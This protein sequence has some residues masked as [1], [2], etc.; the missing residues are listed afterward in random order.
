MKKVGSITSAIGFI[1]IGL[2]LG[3]RCINL[4]IAYF[5][6]RFWF[7]LFIILGIEVV[8]ANKRRDKYKAQFNYLIILAFIISIGMRGYL[9]FSTMCNNKQIGLNKIIFNNE[10]LKT[11]FKNLVYFSDDIYDENEVE[12]YDKLKIDC[13]IDKLKVNVVNGD[14]EIK[15]SEDKKIRVEAI[16]TLKDDK[17]KE[18]YKI[19]AT[20]NG[21]EY[22]L[23]F[24]DKNIKCSDITLYVPD[25]KQLDISDVNGDIKCFDQS[26]K[27]D[28]NINNV[29]GDTELQGDIKECK[30]SIINGDIKIKNDKFSMLKLKTVNGDVELDT[31]EKNI[32]AYINSSL[33]TCSLNDEKEKSIEKILGNGTSKLEIKVSTGLVKVNTEG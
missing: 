8:Y 19:D 27:V 15:K 1:F 6:S 12:V 31:Q 33:G 26:L 3:I 21:R 10:D 29:N 9:G 30:V 11:K 13:N 22:K 16:V 5:M 2:V 18:K 24:K 25:G 28:F 20:R 23:N 7:I 4:N 14:V 17:F 32:N